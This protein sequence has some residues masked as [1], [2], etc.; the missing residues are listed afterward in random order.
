MLSQKKSQWLLLALLSII[1]FALT[2]ILLGFA[3]D[4]I[5][6]REDD[7]GT[8]LNGIIRSWDDFVRVFS[9]DCRSFITPVNYQRTAPNFISGFLRPIQ[10]VAF[11]IVYP[12]F[13]V[14]AEAYFLMHV[15]LHAANAVLFFLFSRLFVPISLAFFAGLMFAFYPNIS[16]LPWIGTVQNS[17]GTMFLL[18]AG[19]AACKALHNFLD[20]SQ[21]SLPASNSSSR[22]TVGLLLSAFLF[23]ISLLSRE[24]G[25]FLPFWIFLGAYF[26]APAAKRAATACRYAWPFFLANIVYTLMRLWAFGVAT[27]PRTIYNLTLRYPALAKYLGYPAVTIAPSPTAHSITPV[28][29]QTTLS[30]KTAP[31]CE[32]IAQKMQVITQKVYAWISSLFNIPTST[33][34][35]KLLNISFVIVLCIVLFIAYREHKKLLFWLCFG[36]AC[37]VWPGILTYPCPRYL[38]MTYPFIIFILIYGIFLLYRDKKPLRLAAGGLLTACCIFLTTYGLKQNRYQLKEAAQSTWGTK[39]RFDEFFSTHTF[40]PDVN[41]FLLSSPF[42]SDIQ[43]IFQA[44]LGNL[45]TT[46]VFDLFTT[47]AEKGMMNCHK[48]YY[49]TGVKST[50]TFIPGGFRLTSGD[51]EHCGWWLRFSDFPIKWSAKDGAYEWTPEQYKPGIWYPC[52]IGKFMIHEMVDDDCVIDIS[53]I[54]DK[55]WIND[56]T[57]FVAWDT[58]QGQYRVIK[59][60]GL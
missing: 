19:F 26:Y 17:L 53:F 57:V 11:S 39:E 50:I 1:L 55:K 5:W 15:A 6:F 21:S 9:A 14:N 28:V 36:A 25:V 54:V 43:S 20:F 29:Q 30:P 12:F 41:F 48:S 22:A 4:C 27:I 47:F 46:V 13:G 58:M 18:L 3:V 49:V 56:K 44:Y 60:L 59:S 35:L 23:L 31:L 51:K 7:L 52:S 45:K 38:N 16:W 2:F 34:L 10:N 33:C 42:V 40:Q 37:T 24:I 8:I 32:Y